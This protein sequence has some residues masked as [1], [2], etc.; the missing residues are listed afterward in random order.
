M[1]RLEVSFLIE[2]RNVDLLLDAFSGQSRL[3]STAD[4]FWAGDRNF[5][6]SSSILHESIM[7]T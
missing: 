7:F 3:S 1:S 6:S 4:S 5:S 2:G